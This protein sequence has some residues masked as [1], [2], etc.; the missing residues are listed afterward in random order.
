MECLPETMPG[1]LPALVATSL[2]QP[3]A[4]SA[5]QTTWPDSDVL[6][7]LVAQNGEVAFRGAM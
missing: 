4:S 7:C 5:R 6:V 3:G 1:W 2:P